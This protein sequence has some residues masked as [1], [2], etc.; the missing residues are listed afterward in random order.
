MPIGSGGFSRFSP[1]PHVDLR[2]EHG[3]LLIVGTLRVKALHTPGHT[4]DSMCLLV[5]DRLFTGDTL[6]IGGTGIVSLNFAGTLPENWVLDLP[7]ESPSSITLMP[8]AQRY[9]PWI[10]ALLTWWVA[11]RAVNLP[12][13]AEFLIATEAE[14]NKVSWTPKRR[15]AQDTVVVLMTTLILTLFLLVVDLFWGWLLSRNIVGV[16]PSKSTGQEQGG[17]AERVRWGAA[18]R[19]ISPARR[20]PPVPDLP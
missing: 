5:E 20:H 14:M 3:D 11:W 8:D 1:A 4:R 6:L 7:F 18:V 2:L 13:F 12:V 17:A 15:L 9:I 16:L 10:L 19:P